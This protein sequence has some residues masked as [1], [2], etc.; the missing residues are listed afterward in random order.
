MR[1]GSRAAVLDAHYVDWIHERGDGSPDT[2]RGSRFSSQHQSR[3]P[4]AFISIDVE[5]TSMTLTLTSC[6]YL[7]LCVNSRYES[8]HPS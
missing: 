7:A 8:R 2:W 5:Y 4:H 1:A 6:P 3:P